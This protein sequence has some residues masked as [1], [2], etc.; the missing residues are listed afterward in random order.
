MSATN[1]M[2]NG[3]LSLFFEN[4]NFANVGDATGLVASTSAGS[5]Y[6]SLHTAT[7]DETGSQT[8]N[9]SAYTSYARVAVARGT[10]TW[11]VS[12]GSATN[13]AAITFPECGTTGSTVTHFGLGSASSGAGNLYVYGQI[14]SGASLAVSDGVQPEFAASALTV[15]LD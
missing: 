4:T 11:T 6:I 9:E 1:A 2:E 10:A 14:N 7:P 8:T 12:T 13:D 5:F 3:I 15:S